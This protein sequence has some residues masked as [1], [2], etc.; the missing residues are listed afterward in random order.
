L[1][2]KLEVGRWAALVIREGDSLG[3]T[4]GAP[5]KE[6]EIPPAIRRRM[7]RLERLAA[8]CTL[9]VLQDD[10]PTDELV[11]A[12]RYGNPETLLT[13]LRGLST[14]ELLSPMGFSGSVHNAV[15]G[16]AGQIRKERLSHTAVAA[17]PDSFLA[18]LV[19][20]WTRLATGECRDVTFTF[21]DLRLPDAYRPFEQ[22]EE[23]TGLVLALRLRAAAARSE[24]M[25]LGKGRAGAFAI[26]EGL[27]RGTRQLA[28]D[29]LEA[30][31]S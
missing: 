23:T 3:E 18:G 8:R 16:L 28:A 11:F 27:K 4:F 19:E 17:G 14:R 2:D 20:C 29:W 30:A 24:G 1:F 25:N 22:E 26:L 5:A 13:L 10:V 7:G 9:G 21:A 6:E 15:P 31:S 12:S